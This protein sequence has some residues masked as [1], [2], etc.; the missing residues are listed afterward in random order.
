MFIGAS[1][2]TEPPFYANVASAPPINTSK[3]PDAGIE[4]KRLICC[5][6]GFIAHNLDTCP[7]VSEEMLTKIL[8]QLEGISPNGT[9]TVM[10]QNQHDLLKVKT[11]KSSSSDLLN[12]MV[13]LNTSQRMTSWQTPSI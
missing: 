13:N 9:G 11:P 1:M 2:D 10:I 12:N 3:T 4:T 8:A 7:D 5:S 6:C